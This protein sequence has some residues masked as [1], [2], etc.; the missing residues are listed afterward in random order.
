MGYDMTKM[1]N[2]KWNFYRNVIKENRR[3]LLNPFYTKKKLITDLYKKNMN[4]TIN[5]NNP[6]TFTEKLNVTK[7][8]KKKMK[9][10]SKLADKDKV[11]EYVKEKIGEDY[12]IKQYFCKSKISVEDLEKLPN[13][14]A[15]KTTSGSGTNYIV[16]DKKKENLA[17]VCKYMNSLLDIKYG[18]IHGEFLYNYI[19]N[20]IV[21]EK[22]IKNKNGKIPD[23]LKCYCFQDN[24]G[25]RRKIL[26]IG[27][28]I[29]D[30]RQ[31]IMFDEDWNVLDIKSNFK[32]L[33]I[34]VKKP[35]NYKKILKVIDKLS[36]DFNFVRV[37]LFLNN[38]KIYFGELTF[39]PT[40][41]YIKFED[42]ETDKLWGSYIGTKN[43]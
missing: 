41:G 31:R 2:E 1:D 37:D 5:Y 6:T 3:K 40:A 32:K 23:D 27:R 19:D 20:K 29:N 34:K 30:D 4:D 25:K 43:K 39:I 36:E 14:F 9:L 18:Y 22:L 35:K 12:L 15:L 26:Y 11:R 24:N 8:D 7:L 17:E 42:D 10:Y 21:A 33:N 38:S 16:M 13:S 28:V